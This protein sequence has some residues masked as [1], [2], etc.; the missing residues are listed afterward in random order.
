M[1]EGKKE[2]PVDLLIAPRAA[3]WQMP[4]APRR[5]QAGV[6][7]GQT[8]STCPFNSV[9]ILEAHMANTYFH[10]VPVTRSTYGLLTLCEKPLLLHQRFNQGHTLCGLRP[11]T[12][13]PPIWSSHLSSCSQTQLFF[14]VPLFF[15]IPLTSLHPLYQFKILPQGFSLC[16][17]GGVFLVTIALMGGV[18]ALS[19][20]DTPVSGS[21]WLCAQTHSWTVKINENYSGLLRGF[22]VGGKSQG[23]QLP[24]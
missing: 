6:C 5:V 20:S 10:S 18:A 1:E 3:W 9:P 21:V 17:R 13:L 23:P 2:L 24:L 22:Q 4:D 12:P 7:R 8:Q 14:P 16:T 11:F 15:S 19:P